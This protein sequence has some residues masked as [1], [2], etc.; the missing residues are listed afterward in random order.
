MG[1]GFCQIGSGARGIRRSEGMRARIRAAL[2]AV[3]YGVAGSGCLM[4]NAGTPVW[5]DARAGEFWSGKGRLLEVTEDRLR[6]RV[7]VRD[8][9]LFVHEMWVM[10]ASVHTRRE[11]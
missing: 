1:L 3:L 8:R 11:P 4:P 2:L 10:C 5:V 9:A 6:C 7:T